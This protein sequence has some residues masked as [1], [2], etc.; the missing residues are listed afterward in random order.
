[1][2]NGR[3]TVVAALAKATH[4]HDCTARFP[5]LE[6]KLWSW[7]KSP[8][9]GS[10]SDNPGMANNSMDG[11]HPRVRMHHHMI[12]SLASTAQHS[13]PTLVHILDNKF[14]RGD[15]LSTLTATLCLSYS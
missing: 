11:G 9:N 6:C 14:N 3:A 10:E 2:T 4:L 7:P 1:M 15:G 8:L 5:A 12:T 13:N